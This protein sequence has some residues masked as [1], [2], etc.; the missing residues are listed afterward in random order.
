LPLK[1]LY[2][3][4]RVPYPPDK[5]EKIRAFHQLK[6][7]AGRHEVDLFT[8]T[9]PAADA[10]EYAPLK[11]WCHRIVV[12]RLSPKAARLRSLPYLLTRT[13]LTLPCFYSPELQEEIRQAVLAR[14]YD[15]VFVYCSAMAQYISQVDRIPVFTDLVDVDSDKW[16]QY[17]ASTLFPA[18]LV[19]RREAKCL[20]QYERELCKR[21]VGIIVAT[22][23]EASLVREIASDAN[24][25]A[26]PNGVD[27]E[28]FRPSGEPPGSGAPAIVFTGDMRYL[29]NVEAVKFFV[30]RV[31]P[32]VR[33]DVADARFWIVGRDP[34]PAVRRLATVPGVEVTGFVPDVRKY[35][36]GARVA[37]APFSIAAGIQNKVLEALAYELPVV[38]TRKVLQGL[39]GAV[40]DIVH[41]GDSPEE[42]AGSV[43]QLLKDPLLARQIGRE[44]RRR[45]LAEYSWDRSGALL[46]DLIER[47]VDPTYRHPGRS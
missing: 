6:A 38:A 30:S 45:V 1:I 26:I 13:P 36:A 5:G 19:Y 37:V 20:R 27:G 24:V 2:I 33:R 22:E 41:T 32:L 4:H 34:A 14:G 31:F 8:L 46:L 10:A 28:F 16:A 29:P 17:A 12:S 11:A 23:R 18:S 44:G 40:A 39:A 35:L 42:L 47:P 43:V 25:H 3:C 15:R 9:D 7:L 21:S